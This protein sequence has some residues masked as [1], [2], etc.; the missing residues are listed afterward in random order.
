VP[1]IAGSIYGGHAATAELA[2]D[3]VSVA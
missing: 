1:W 2:F 3:R